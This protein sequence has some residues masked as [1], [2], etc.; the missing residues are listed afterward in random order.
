MTNLTASLPLP[1]DDFAA[2]FRVGWEAVCGDGVPLPRVLPMAPRL[3][4]MG[5]SLF[6]LGVRAGVE[7][8]TG[9]ED[10]DDIGLRP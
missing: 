7:A 1:H 6:T 8:A 2:G 9:V 3:T 4:T 10:L 5:Y